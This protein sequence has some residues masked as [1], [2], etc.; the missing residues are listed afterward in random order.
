MLKLLMVAALFA[1]VS[2]WALADDASVPLS[3]TPVV[4]QRTIQRQIGDAKLDDISKSTSDEEE[5]YDVG[6]TGRD[7][8]DRDFSVAADG[9][10]LSVEVTLAGTPAAAQT[11]I[12]SELEGGTLDSID[13]NIADSEISYDVS[14]AGGDGEKRNFTVAED[15]TLL[16]IEVA[17]GGT[18]AAVRRTIAS[19]SAG[20]QVKT[21]D[22]NFDQ[23]GTNYDVEVGGGSGKSFSVAA[24]GTLTS[25]RIALAKLPPV[26][27]RAIEARIGDGTVLRVD[28]CFEKERGVFPFEVEGR[29]DGKPYDFSVGPRGRFLGMDD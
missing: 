26:V 29:K 2:E 10:L 16:S 19:Q 23:D 14:G 3:Q 25:E 15:G 12:R 22:E 27:R 6:A 18:P 9:T 7:G 11:A 21:V 24:D 1:A 5:V 20:G 13:K 28:R 8:S 4:V 17:P